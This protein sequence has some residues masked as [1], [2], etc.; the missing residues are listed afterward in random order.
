MVDTIYLQESKL[1][2]SENLFFEVLLSGPAALFIQHT[3]SI[4][5]AGKQV[6]YGGTSQVLQPHR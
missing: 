5:P 6:G 4:L 3:G 2:R 1:Y